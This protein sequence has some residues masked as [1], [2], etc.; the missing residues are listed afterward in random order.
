MIVIFHSNSCPIDTW[1]L[2]LR[3][4][5]YSWAVWHTAQ[6]LNN[7][8]DI[9]MFSA[10][11][12]P[13][14]AVLYEWK[15]CVPARPNIIAA[16]GAFCW[17]QLNSYIQGQW[18]RPPRVPPPSSLVTL[19]FWLFACF[20]YDYGIFSCS[21]SR[22]EGNRLRFTGHMRS[23]YHLINCCPKKYVSHSGGDPFEFLPDCW[24]CRPMF[25]VDFR[26]VSAQKLSDIPESP[27]FKS[28]FT[29]PFHSTLYNS[30]GC[31]SIVK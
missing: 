26:S 8:N 27:P 19:V 1:L 6:K 3:P 23:S 5:N 14:I 28:L 29:D 7:A 25:S 24:S 11:C 12:R 30:S 16:L 4:T 17:I 9:E 18:R 13:E 31:Y 2:S 15:C 21:R 22:A 10:P 20:L